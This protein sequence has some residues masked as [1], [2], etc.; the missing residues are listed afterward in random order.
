MYFFAF[1]NEIP[2]RNIIK[3]I[4][5]ILFKINYKITTYMHSMTSSGKKFLFRYLKITNFRKTGFSQIF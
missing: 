3:K 5:T 4:T 1:F 2:V